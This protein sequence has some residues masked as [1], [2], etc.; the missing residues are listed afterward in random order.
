VLGGQNYNATN[1]PPN[2]NL[3]DFWKSE[4]NTLP[5]TLL[6][7]ESICLPNEI[8]NL[9]V[10]W[11]TAS[12]INCVAFLVQIDINGKIIEKKIAGHGNTTQINN[13][14]LHLSVPANVGLNQ[15]KI[16]LLEVDADGNKTNI[17]EKQLDCSAEM[18]TDILVFPNPSND[19]R[20]QIFGNHI[21]VSNIKVIDALG[22]EILFTYSVQDKFIS[23]VLEP[24]TSAGIYYV[25]YH[26]SKLKLLVY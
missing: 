16:R 22:R 24:Q 3:V 9:Q 20:F 21:Q 11:R 6:D 17:V 7:F 19:G 25:L 5:V 26:G 18:E 1:T 13:Y 4:C 12:E 15:A 14:T 8:E 2:T 23:I 10:N